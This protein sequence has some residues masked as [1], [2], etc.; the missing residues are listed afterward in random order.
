MEL[1][2]G[3]PLLRSAID[4]VPA[5]PLLL[6]KESP[7]V[8]RDSELG[9]LEAIFDGC[10]SEPMAGAA[11]VTGPSG[12][13]KSRLFREL[14]AR[15][16]R[17]T[18]RT[19]VLIGRGDALGG[20]P[21]GMI[22]DAI[23]RAAGIRDG[24]P[25][26]ARQRKLAWWVGRRLSG[27]TAARATAFL[28]EMT[29]TPFPDDVDE[30]LRAARGDPMLMGDSMRAAWEAVLAAE[31]AAH[32]VLLVLEDLHLG[33]AATVRLVDSTLRN[34]GDLPLVVLGLGRPEVH[35]RFPRLWAERAPHIVQLGP[36]PRRASEALVRDALGDHADD[37]VVARI[38][39]RGGGN[40]FH[41][42]ELVRAV[43][44]GRGDA[45][46]A[47][48][49]DAV[50]ARLD[51]EGGEAKRILRAASVFGARFSRAGIA[52][53]TGGDARAAGEWLEH[54]TARELI[55]EAGSPALPG[56]ADYVFRHDLVREA[57][58]A[59]LIDDDRALGHLLAGEWMEETGHTDA[60][61][62]A[63]HFRR[64]GQP[65]R[66]TR[67]L[68]R[69]AEAGPQA[70]QAFA[71]LTA[72]GAVDSARLRDPAWRERFL[73]DLPDNARPLAPAEEALA[74]QHAGVT[75]SGS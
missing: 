73:A 71:E 68:L 32:P 65:W 5:A 22:A 61:A 56:D 1:D 66:S 34:L 63:S 43:A 16:S 30:A 31:C 49:L 67:W 75:H 41:L 64:G 19:E 11:L 12:A 6:G 48:V 39:A 53:L 69:A 42:Q 60:M 52:A 47:S 62:M 58:Y 14:E 8:G 27:P 29:S 20:S 18:E 46:P 25:I 7:H 10:A 33:D 38:L 13:G 28:G 21:Y 23:Q 70:A 2:A 72:L 37:E 3:G 17:R 44:A 74:G 40:P 4:A 15:L 36:L 54:L 57:A 9:I 59:T 35:A 51:A 24:E 55:A 45:F 26:A 50:E